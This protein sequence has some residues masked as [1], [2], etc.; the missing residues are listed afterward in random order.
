M[1]AGRGIFDP[2]SVG[3]RLMGDQEGEF[4][5]S[6]ATGLIPCDGPLGRGFGKAAMRGEGVQNEGQPS[7]DGKA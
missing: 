4:P 6:G 1:S 2:L 3:L 7:R 5:I